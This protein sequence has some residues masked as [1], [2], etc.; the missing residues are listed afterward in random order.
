MSRTLPRVLFVVAIFWPVLAAAQHADNDFEQTTN[1]FD[2]QEQKQAPKKKAA[3]AGFSSY[4]KGFK[5]I[6]TLIK[7]DGRQEVFAKHLE[8]AL[9]EEFDSECSPCKAFLRTFAAACK[10]PT[11]KLSKVLPTPTPDPEDGQ[12]DET[13][14]VVA[15]TPVAVKPKLQPK[16]PVQREPSAA[17]L[18]SVSALFNRMSEDSKRVDF[19]A[20]TVARLCSLMR[21]PEELKPGEIIYLDILSEYML[22]PFA[23]VLKQQA[24]GE[25]GASVHEVEV[26]EQVQVDDLFE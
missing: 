21:N 20:R 7:V 26:Q 17:L 6:C 23:R 14:N 12:H 5:D 13:K 1:A 19:A 18:D 9:A 11:E 16:F 3:T 10:V 4:A 2:R 15:A 22:A 24:Q 25:A 8:F